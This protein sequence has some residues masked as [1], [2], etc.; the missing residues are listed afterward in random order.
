MTEIIRPV[1]EVFLCHNS[2]DKPIVRELRDSLRCRE[3]CTWFDED[4][5]IPG[6]PWQEAL[7]DA[8]E[9]IAAVAVCVG[10][11]G[12]GPWQSREMRAY[13]AEFVRNGDAVIPVLLPG[14]DAT[15]DLP[16]FLR[17]FMWVDLREGFSD[18]AMH[19]LI[20]GIRCNPP[21]ETPVLR[22]L[23]AEAD[24]PVRKV[25]AGEFQLDEEVVSEATDVASGAEDGE[26]GP[27]VAFISELLQ[28]VCNLLNSDEEPYR[29]LAAQL[30]EQLNE[31]GDETKVNAVFL[32]EAYEKKLDQV[33]RA[34]QDFLRWSVRS[35]EEEGVRRLVDAMG[36]VVFD[37]NS[38][39]GLR[40]ELNAGHVHV[41]SDTDLHLCELVFTAL[42]KEPATWAPS[43]AI[44]HDTVCSV[45]TPSTNPTDRAREIR[46]RLVETYFKDRVFRGVGETDAE[47]ERRVDRWAE[48][49]LPAILEAEREDNKPWFVLFAETADALKTDME[50]DPA[51]WTQVVKLERSDEK[52]RFVC[53]LS[54][55][56]DWLA[57]LR[58]LDES[59]PGERE[60]TA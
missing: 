59:D 44:S 48:Q 12:F 29:T 30:A 18:D 49:D 27:K 23:R 21:G 39:D 47:Y 24:L 33:T 41:P 46:R 15:P 58:G 35:G 6:R 60:G 13:I 55:L 50:N 5:L 28:V 1:H 38:M 14:V 52:Q 40:E 8:I 16:I 43:R 45:A 34:L 2:E 19:P 4:Q 3:I 9:S 26:S 51:L 32:R 56:R 36:T 22:V 10:P 17:Q 57:M 42:Y 31:E 20:C 54:K 25:E 11:S 53:D 37:S 7:E